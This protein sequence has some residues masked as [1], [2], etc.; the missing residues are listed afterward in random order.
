MCHIFL[1][2]LTLEMALLYFPAD[3]IKYFVFGLHPRNFSW[4][5]LEDISFEF[6]KTNKYTF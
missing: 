6:I 2:G 4:I 5:Y 3:M 1:Q